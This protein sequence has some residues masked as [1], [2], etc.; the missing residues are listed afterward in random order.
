MVCYARN[1]SLYDIVGKCL[2]N[3]LNSLHKDVQ[4]SIRCTVQTPYPLSIPG[5]VREQSRETLPYRWCLLT[6]SLFRYLFGRGA[7]VSLTSGSPLWI[8]F[9]HAHE[10]TCWK[11]FLLLVPVVVGVDFEV[12]LPLG[13]N[14]IFFKDGSH[15]ASRLTGA[16]IDT[17]VRVNLELIVLVVV[18]FT[19][20][21]MN[22]IHRA[23]IDARAVFHA[24]TRR[25]NHIGHRSL[26]S[27]IDIHAG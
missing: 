6:Y 17:L 20:S 11:C 27:L 1:I 5:A 26:S 21:G 19:G 3:L 2:K 25:G 14:S 15:G 16:A 24:D 12:L 13:R 9:T 23:H 8:A 4:R 10:P 7:G 18:G 22:A